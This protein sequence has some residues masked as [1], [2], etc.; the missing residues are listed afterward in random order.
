MVALRQRIRFWTT[1]C[2]LE[3][4]LG[5]YRPRN[6]LV[7]HVATLLARCSAAPLLSR[8]CRPESAKGIG[9]VSGIDAAIRT[10]SAFVGILQ[11]HPERRP[12]GGFQSDAG[13]LETIFS[14][15]LVWLWLRQACRTGLTVTIWT[16]SNS[17]WIL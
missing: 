3:R 4:G 15:A 2:A 9:N 8:L 10:R 1:F 16:F 6:G 12:N 5:D 14:D 17:N 7:I 13:T 11:A